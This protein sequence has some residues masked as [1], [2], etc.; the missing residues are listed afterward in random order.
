M[1]ASA[2]FAAVPRSEIADISAANPGRDGTGTIVALFTAGAGGSRL[3][4]ITIKADGNTTAGMVRL[5]KK[6]GGGAW[7]LWREYQVTAIVP[8]ASV[9]TFSYLDDEIGEIMKAGLQIGAST[10]NAESFKVH[11]NGGDF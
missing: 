6:D 8:S 2:N 7:K 1:G 5:F 3:D 9:A 4:R 11:A 10:H